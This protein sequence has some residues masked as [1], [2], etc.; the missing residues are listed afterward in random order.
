[1][2]LK[3]EIVFPSSSKMAKN[4]ERPKNKRTK[5]K[6]MRLGDTMTALKVH[7]GKMKV[8]ISG[9]FFVK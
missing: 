7:I 2:Y 9:F 1:M 6:N 5:W 8:G 4:L 3:E